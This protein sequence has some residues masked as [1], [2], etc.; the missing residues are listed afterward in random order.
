MLVLGVAAVGAGTLSRVPLA[1]LTLTALAAFEAVSGLPAAA[2]QLGQA[3][4]SARRI[5]AVL[6]A[7]IPVGDQPARLAAARPAR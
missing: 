4:S 5:C 3:A 7:P 2:L 6:D 1:V